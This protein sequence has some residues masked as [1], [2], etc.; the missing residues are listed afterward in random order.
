MQYLW[1]ACILNRRQSFLWFTLEGKVRR[2]PYSSFSTKQ[3]VENL[4]FT[5][6]SFRDLFTGR[7]FYILMEDASTSS[8]MFAFQMEVTYHG[9]FI[10]VFEP[11]HDGYLIHGIPVITSI[12]PIIPTAVDVANAASTG[13]FREFQQNSSVESFHLLVDDLQMGRA[14][15]MPSCGHS[16]CDGA[17]Q[18]NVSLSN[19]T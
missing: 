3:R 6:I 18:T 15:I 4:S 17:H 10:T 16:F 13:I 9:S 7:C 11:E 1:N 19:I 8:V 5:S 14:T 12:H 2:N